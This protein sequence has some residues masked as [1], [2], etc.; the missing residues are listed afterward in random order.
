MAR[1]KIRCNDVRYR[2][3]FVEVVSGI[4]P[5]HINLE[6]WNMHADMNISGKSLESPSIPDDAIVANTEVELN[7]EQA[8]A[9][10]EVLQASIQEVERAN[11]NE[12]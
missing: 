12:A 5:Q 10:V 1:Q 3:G 6:V 11:D 9:L 2:Q 7:L 8:K 4:H